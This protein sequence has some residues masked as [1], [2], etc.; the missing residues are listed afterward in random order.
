MSHEVLPELVSEAQ[1]S[2]VLGWAVLAWCIAWLLGGITLVAVHRRWWSAAWSAYAVL[3][4]LV[5]WGA[6]GVFRYMTRV[7]MTTG[8]AGLHRVSMMLLCLGI[9]LVGGG[10]LGGAAAYISRAAAPR[11]GR[12]ADG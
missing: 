10:L 7:D 6:W 3:C 5:V 2:A 8:E 9:F 12:S 4:G 11:P 1:F